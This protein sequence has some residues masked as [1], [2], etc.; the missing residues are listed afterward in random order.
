MPTEEGESGGLVLSDPFGGRWPPIASRRT[1]ATIYDA[2]YVSSANIRCAVKLCINLL[3]GG[4]IF[5]CN[6]KEGLD[7][8]RCVV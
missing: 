3:I 7:G 2:P 1:R 8:Q 6:T 4:H 5:I